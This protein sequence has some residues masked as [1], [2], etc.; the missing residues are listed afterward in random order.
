MEAS[1]TSCAKQEN[2]F[3]TYL[4]NEKFIYI[5]HDDAPQQKLIRAIEENFSMANNMKVN[6]VASEYE[7]QSNERMLNEIILKEK[8]A[9]ELQ[10]L[11]NETQEVKQIVSD[12]LD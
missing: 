2:A 1:K 10:L 12:N 3:V 7:L 8:S 5:L 9:Q 11:D 4:T 6:S